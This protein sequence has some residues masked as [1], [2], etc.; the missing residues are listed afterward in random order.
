MKTGV[1]LIEEERKRQIEVEGWSIDH[2][3]KHDRNEL[4]LAAACYALPQFQR[5]QFSFVYKFGVGKHIW[6]PTLWPFSSK[7]WKPTPNDRI[8]ELQKAGAL[9]AAEIDRL[10]QIKNETTDESN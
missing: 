5:N 2:D 4:S 9:I 3:A 1:E 6:L 7:F 10:Q 8:K